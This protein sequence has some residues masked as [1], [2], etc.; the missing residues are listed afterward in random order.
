MSLG[1]RILSWFVAICGIGDPA[2]FARILRNW[3]REPG[4][5][6]RVEPGA[7]ATKVRS[8]GSRCSTRVPALPEAGVSRSSLAV[9]A[10]AK[11]TFERKPLHDQ[12]T[13]FAE[14]GAHD[15]V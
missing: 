7:P 5:H 14:P 9:R 8:S 13:A 11:A 15:R 10:R 12:G 1:R 3:E 6:V 4:S 2:R